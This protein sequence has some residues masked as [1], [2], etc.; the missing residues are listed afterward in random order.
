MVLGLF[1]SPG[2]TIRGVQV[3]DNPLAFESGLSPSRSMGEALTEFIKSLPRCLI[4]RG[5]A[6]LDQSLSGGEMSLLGDAASKHSDK[7]LVPV[8]DQWQLGGDLRSWP[9]AGLELGD[10]EDRVDTACRW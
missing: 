8:L 3:V 4:F 1:P 9:D 6:P 10:V 7:N 5:A 2:V